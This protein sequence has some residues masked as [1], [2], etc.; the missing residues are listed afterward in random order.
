MHNLHPGEWY[1]RF[2]CIQCAS[3][4]VLFPDLSKGTAPIRA[5]YEVTCDKCRHKDFY[6]ADRIERYHHP[7]DAQPIFSN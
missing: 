3:K 2:T 7:E 4:Q 1:L 6:D 5:I